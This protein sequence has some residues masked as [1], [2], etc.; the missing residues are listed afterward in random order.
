MS[1]ICNSQI[2]GIG[3]Y[4]PEMVVHSRDLMREIKSAQLG[5]DERLFE[6][7]TGIR[8]R[9]FTTE[10][11]TYTM[12]S[13]E[14]SHQAIVDAGID[15]ADID[16]TIY[17]G[18]D[19]DVAEPSL[20]H[21]I[22]NILGAKKA[23]CFDINNACLGLLNGLSIANAYLASGAAENVLI[24]TAEKSSRITLDVMRQ[25]KEEGTKAALKRLLGAFT[26]GDAGGAFVVSKAK[27]GLGAQHM[28][29][30]TDSSISHLC[31]YK[32]EGKKIEFVMDME[33][34]S[35]A[36]VEWH[37]RF[38]DDTYNQLAWQPSEI[39]KVFCHQV[40]AKPHKF[41]AELAQVSLERV[42]TTYDRFANMTSATFAVNMSINRPQPGE[43]ILMLGAGSGCSGCQ[44]GMQF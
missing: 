21:E 24:C 33:N 12:M 28:N 31:Y 13:V 34:I 6:R 43:K 40:G 20:A 27:E 39:N 22:S 8:E 19:K 29:F 26:I 1:I 25:I 32:R 23:I 36:M 5:Y 2:T 9:R 42:P 41:M 17:C 4:I 35:A 37:S 16:F 14:A 10:E 3:A 30:F 15:P 11:E 38:L 18:I 7:A 44:I